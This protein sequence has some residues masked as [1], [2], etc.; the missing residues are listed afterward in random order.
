MKLLVVEPVEPLSLSKTMIGG[1]EVFGY[2]DVLPIP[3]QTTIVGA[4]GAA[5]Q[6]ELKVQEDP[7][8]AL[9]QLV[10]EVKRRGSCE[11]PLILGPILQFKELKYNYILVGNI[12]VPLDF[13]DT[14]IIVKDRIVYITKDLCTV[15]SCAK[16]VA[17]VNIG[18][19]LERRAKA[20]EA[21]KKVMLGYTYRYGLIG[22]TTYNGKPLTPRFIYIVNCH[23]I[24]LNG[25]VRIGGEGRTARIYT[26]RLAEDFKE[27][28]HRICSP[29]NIDKPGIYMSINYVPL[30]PLKDDIE[31]KLDTV[32][33]LEFIEDIMDIQGIAVAYGEMPKIKIER[34]GLGYSEVVQ[35]RRPQVLSLIPGTVFR[36]TKSG[37]IIPKINL[38]NYLWT[39][40]FAT[41]LRISDAL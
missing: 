10:E 19:A 7:T 32:S 18:I 28:T 37:R 34:L 3:S 16:P 40:G 14:M 26:Q 25:V 21:D 17:M 23:N 30:I 39:I 22:Y 35:A 20:L 24:E 5:L 33:G 4:L 38:T 9:I 36:I 15:T 31:F 8:E 11:D 13:I 27:L 12:F 41:L 29:I 6:I 1:K 2:I